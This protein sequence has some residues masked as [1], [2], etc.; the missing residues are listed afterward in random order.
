MKADNDLELQTNEHTSQLTEM[1]NN[2]EKAKEDAEIPDHDESGFLANISRKMRSPMSEIT[3]MMNQAINTDLTKEERVYVKI[4]K[5]SADS[6]QAII[7]NVL[8]FCKIEAA[9]LKME[10]Q[11]KK[12]QRQ[13]FESRNKIR[14][15]FDALN[16]E[17]V[18]INED[19][20]IESLN[21]AFL[22]ITDSTYVDVIGRYLFESENIYPPHSIPAF[23]NLLIHAFK[24]GVTQ[25]GFHE[26]IDDH[27]EKRYKQIT[28]LPLKNSAEQV[29][30]IAI[31][32]KDIT[33]DKRKSDKIKDLNKKLIKSFAHIK[34]QNKKLKQTLTMLEDSQAKMLESEKMASIGQ[35]AAGVAHEI[36]NPIGFVGSNLKTLM[37]YQEVIN[38][39]LTVYHELMIVLKA[40]AVN[41][42]LSADMLTKTKQV[43]DVE[44]NVD[45][46]FVQKDI[47]DLVKDCY[48]GIE[49]IQNIV[50]ELK[51]FAHPGKDQLIVAD[52]NKRL[53][54]SLNVVY[55]ELKYKAKVNMNFEELP[56]IKCFPQQL[57]QV[58]INILM[59]AGQSIETKGEIHIETKYVNDNIEI[60]IRDN[61]SGIPEENLRRIFEP[62]F[63]TKEVGQGTGLGMHIAYNIIKK[64][65]GT[66]DVRSRIGKGT[67]FTIRLPMDKIKI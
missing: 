7:N 36:N 60:T 12:L 46:V 65:K 31:V 34:N 57:D 15:V 27:G 61:G 58:F 24:T 32:S 67:T 59:N 37:E 45:I 18:V 42:N 20:R 9:K 30:Q 54:S 14:I 52:I 19:F 2:V 35:L 26:G 50:L 10:E 25:Y 23:K 3:R 29:F 4:T 41:V 6:L 40:E 64:H 44:K 28:C 13:L 53:E 43:M 16:E 51:A 62:F 39:M 21:H 33:D 17:I 1:N 56:Q 47:S 22:K 48:E 5:M 49:R 63:T 55:N 8:D 11:H 38:K 66:I